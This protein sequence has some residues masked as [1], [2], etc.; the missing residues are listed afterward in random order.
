MGDRG[1]ASASGILL[2]WLAVLAGS[3][4]SAEESVPDSRIGTRTAPLLL[5]SRSDVR[6][7][8][9]LSEKQ[10]VEAE[11]AV[12]TLH[13]QAARLRGQKG[14][15]IQEARKR[16][17]LEQEQWLHTHL[18]PP[19]LERLIQIDLQWE[20]ASAVISRPVVAERLH[21][22]PTQETQLRAVL[23]RR[24]TERVAG[25]Y[26][27]ELNSRVERDVM[28]ILSERQQEEWKKLVGMPFR[29]R[30]ASA[31]DRAKR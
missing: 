2:L 5:L 15:A 13:A 23:N 16:I 17:D 14:E 1:L 26:D 11:R 18:T 27:E 3:T 4:Q 28:T 19:Q 25:K 8:L 20:G 9:R 12:A 30:L 29:A 24:N 6:R 7:E 22:T 10:V 31:K 21:L